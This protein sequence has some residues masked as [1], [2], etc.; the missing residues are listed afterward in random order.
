[1]V[2]PFIKR[3]SLNPNEFSSPRPISNLSFLSKI[4]EESIA[5]HLE[6]YLLENNLYLHKQSRYRRH[7]STETVLI[8]IFNDVCCALDNGKNAVLVLLELSSALT[9][10]IMRFFQSVCKLDS[11]LL[12][13]FLKGPL[14]FC[15]YISPNED[16][17]LAHGLSVLLYADDTQ[18]YISLKPTQKEET[19]IRQESCLADLSNWFSANKLVCKPNKSNIVY[20]SSKYRDQSS[21]V[22]IS[23]GSSV[24]HLVDVALGVN[25]DKHLT[26]KSTIS[27]K[28]ASSSLL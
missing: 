18:L 19:K 7:H 5:I 22:S 24:L 25:L 6:R 10:L 26:M 9:R 1:M 15:L 16:I 8:K 4:I 21:S 27:S 20:F 14:T 11:V 23:F 2:I 3:N 17:I 28:T 13:K 12:A